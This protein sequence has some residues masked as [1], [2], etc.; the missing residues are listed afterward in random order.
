M[1]L[2]GEHIKPKYRSI[3]DRSVAD[4]AAAP[5][6]TTTPFNLIE[7]NDPAAELEPIRTTDESVSDELPVLAKP[8]VPTCTPS[9]RALTEPC[10]NKYSAEMTFSPET[11]GVTASADES[12]SNVLQNTRATPF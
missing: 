10:A 5:D 9:T 12:E 1:S 11:A 7:R 2:A 3:L 6:T 4:M 8:A